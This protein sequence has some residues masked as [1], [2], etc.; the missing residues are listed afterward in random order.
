MLVPAVK[1]V[2]VVR[3]LGVPAAVLAAVLLLAGCGGSGTNDGGMPTPAGGGDGSTGTTGTPTPDASVSKPTVVPTKTAAQPKTQVIVDP[4]KFGENPAVQGLMRM[5]PTYFRALVAGDDKIVRDSFPGFFY[6]DTAIGINEAKRNGW[7]MR[8]PGS[9]VVVGTEQQPYRVVRLK[10]CRSQT[11]QYWNPKTRRWVK[12]TPKGSPEVY[13]M[14]ETGLGWMMY[15]L[16]TPIP[17]PYSCAT[18]RY[19]A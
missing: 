1:G 16:V 6:A 17:K 13:D 3:R 4:G 18:V 15:R 7:V 2:I 9:I 11:T 12:V 10:T 14:V 5:Y 19:P 8:P